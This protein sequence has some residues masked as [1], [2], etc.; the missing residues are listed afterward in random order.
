MKDPELETQTQLIEGYLNGSTREFFIVTSWIE[1]VVNNYW[2]GLKEY[3]EDIIQDIRL[4]LY[5]NLKQNKF[6]R[7]SLLKTYVYRIAKYTCIDF[8]RKTYSNPSTT[9][10]DLPDI[11]EERNIIDGLISKEKEKV[12]QTVLQELADKCREILQMVFVDRLSYNEI[13][14]ELN[15]AEGTVKS[16]VSRCISKAIQL[17]KKYWNYKQA[18]TTISIKS[19]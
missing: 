2:W 15:I 1:Q 14:A 17:R 11:A 10:S 19:E 7:A 13:S 8:L 9:K 16:R 5:I 12:V 3:R 18:D 6:H 4:K